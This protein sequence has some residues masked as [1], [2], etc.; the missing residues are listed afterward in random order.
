MKFSEIGLEISSDREEITELIDYQGFCGGPTPKT[1]EKVATGGRTMDEGDTD[2]VNGEPLFG[3]LEPEEAL[4]KFSSGWAPWVLD[5]R[6]Q[7]ENDIVSLPFTDH[8][9]PH[10]QVGVKD[11]PSQGDVLVYCK[12]GVRGKKA[13]QKLISEG[14]DPGRIH[15]LEGGIMRWRQKVDPS[16]PQY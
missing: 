9:V 11:I 14:V 6:L 2:E 4:Q 5:V 13:C 1:P 15:N 16:M 12:A 3:M 7:T 10:R 8:L